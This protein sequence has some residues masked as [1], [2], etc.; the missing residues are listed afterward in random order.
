MGKNEKIFCKVDTIYDD[1][2]LE[3]TLCKKT[4]KVYRT[5]RNFGE[6]T[7]F[8]KKGTTAYSA[9]YNYIK[10]IT[11]DKNLLDDSAESWE[12]YYEVRDDLHTNI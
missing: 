1:Y 6:I 5:H 12:E 10:F 4:I 9:C 3:L 11:S 2:I 8:F 7:R